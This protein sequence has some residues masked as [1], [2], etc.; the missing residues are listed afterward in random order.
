[1]DLPFKILPMDNFEK[2]TNDKDP[3]TGV[4]IRLVTTEERV[5]KLEKVRKK[6]KD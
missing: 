2:Y 1:M 5:I 3:T 4:K 6:Q